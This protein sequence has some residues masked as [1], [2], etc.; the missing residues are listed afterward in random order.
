M[1]ADVAPAQ[2][3]TAEGV[4]HELLR[5]ALL[6]KLAID[7]GDPDDDLPEVDDLLVAKYPLPP[8]DQEQPWA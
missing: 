8:T 4:A 3:H 1:T 7:L 2:R 6:C 5:T